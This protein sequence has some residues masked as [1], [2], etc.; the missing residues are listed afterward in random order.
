MSRSKNIYTL[1]KELEEIDWN[2]Y[3]VTDDNISIDKPFVSDLSARDF[4]LKYFVKGGKDLVTSR[5]D[6]TNFGTARAEHTVSIFF[7]VYLSIKTLF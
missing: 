2:Y 7:L 1:I 4:I 3:A 5:F 6:V